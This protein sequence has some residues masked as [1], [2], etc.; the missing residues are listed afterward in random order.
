MDCSDCSRGLDQPPSSAILRPMTRAG[1]SSL[2]SRTLTG[3]EVFGR[4]YTLEELVSKM[5][6]DLRDSAFPSAMPWWG[7]RCAS[8]AQRRKTMMA[9]P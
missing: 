6:S 5:V 2:S 1:S 8:L 9:M 4:R 7:V 3:T